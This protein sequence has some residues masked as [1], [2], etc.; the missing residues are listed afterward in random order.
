MNIIF[1]ALSPLLALI[2]QSAWS[3][4]SSV[5][6]FADSSAVWRLVLALLLLVVLI[7]LVLWGLK[8]LQGLQHK[9]VKSDIAVIA[10]QTVGPKERLLL[11]EVAGKRLL[12]GATAHQITCLK[13][14]DRPGEQ[15][16]ELIDEQLHNEK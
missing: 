5:G 4:G 7:P 1:V 6:Q 9:F 3:A 10:T 15:F 12:L 11:V 16:A 2:S 14:F 13:E 8:K